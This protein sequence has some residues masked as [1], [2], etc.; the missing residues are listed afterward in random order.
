MVLKLISKIV[1][2]ICIVIFLSYALLY[3]NSN[4]TNEYV[5]GISGKMEKLKKA[6]GK[7]MVIV[8]GSN[9]TFGIDTKVMEK[10][11]GLPVVN[12]AL[13][14]ALSVKY[15]MEQVEPYLK[16]GDILIMS[17]EPGGLA[18]DH[19]WNH[20]VGTEVPLMPTYNFPE[21]GI[22]F[23]DRN[24]FETSI[25]SFFNT[26][27][28]YVRW[29]P[30]EKRTEIRSVY[31]RRV[32]ESDNILP[33]Y[34][35]GSYAD[36]LKP[37]LLKK[38][39]KNSLLINGL[40]AYKEEFEKKGITFYMTPAVVVKG[41]LKEVEIMP[42]WEY[43]SEQTQIPLLNYEKTYVFEKGY[44]L[45]S[46]HHTNLEGRDMRTKSLIEDI[47]GQNLVNSDMNNFQ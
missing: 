6:E 43:I 25:A 8:G 14:G 40:R 38:P 17:R 26:I 18:G 33:E 31:D 44:F 41:Y 45:D 24:L 15:M 13:H 3:L 19:R 37:K 22:L 42:F 21:I 32:F 10:E 23:S 29:C 4:Y 5:G 28:L 36:T 16:K 7:K 47:L 34:L 35:K 27:K 20:A 46:P 39:G 11:L 1:L 2:F 9:A 30:F 12:M